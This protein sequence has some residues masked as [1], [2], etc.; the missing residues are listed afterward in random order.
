MDCSQLYISTVSAGCDE[1][2]A[3]YGLGLEI[4]E[5][6]TAANLDAPIPEVVTAAQCHRQAAKRFVFHAPFNELC[7]AAIDPLAVSLA[8]HR[9]AQALAA[10]LVDL[11]SG[12]EELADGKLPAYLPDWERA[13]QTA[14]TAPEISC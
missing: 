3:R 10:G 7:P 5:Y 6:C 12:D 2:A 1:T 13:L 14:Q 8:R 4:A 11:M 9:Y